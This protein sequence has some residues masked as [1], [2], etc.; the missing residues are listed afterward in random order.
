MHR[1][2]TCQVRMRH[3]LYSRWNQNSTQAGS[4]GIPALQQ[5]LDACLNRKRRK[6]YF[7]QILYCFDQVRTLHTAIYPV[8]FD[9]RLSGILCTF[10]SSLEAGP[11]H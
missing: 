5:N 11:Y 2:E 1:F 4:H 7:G 8:E 9:M 3:I 6:M 10:L